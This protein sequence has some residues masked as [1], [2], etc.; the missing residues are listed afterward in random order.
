MAKTYVIL[1]FSDYL[2]A[3]SSTQRSEA[4][5]DLAEAFE[6]RVM[7]KGGTY[8][9]HHMADLFGN[10]RAERHGPAPGHEVQGLLDEGWVRSLSIEAAVFRRSAWAAMI[11]HCREADKIILSVHGEKDDVDNVYCESQAATIR[12][13]TV[14]GVV[15]FLESILNVVERPDPT[16]TLSVCYSARSA[17][18]LKHHGQDLS[19][20]DL[21]SSL[22]FQIFCRLSAIRPHL[23]LT[24]RT[25]AVSPDVTTGRLRVETE[26][27]IIANETLPR[28]FS[29][30]ERDLLVDDA[31]NAYR[32]L[33]AALEKSGIPKEQQKRIQDRLDDWGRHFDPNE[34]DAIIDS[35]DRL[36]S[37]TRSMLTSFLSAISAVASPKWSERFAQQVLTAKGIAPRRH[38][39]YTLIQASE[40]PPLEKYGKFIYQRDHKNRVVVTRWSGNTLTRLARLH[41]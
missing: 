13:G 33:D 4:I 31:T 6:T 5:K 39:L 23:R 28:E 16:I 14:D 20:G 17:A 40:S 22:A 25:G 3:G 11:N 27:T 15:C 30:W 18:Y 9:V 8:Y 21:R 12:C 7:T 41:A 38:E 34:L 36:D 24:A 26:E 37:S 32:Q 2:A 29:D 10:L 1:N 19:D 35:I